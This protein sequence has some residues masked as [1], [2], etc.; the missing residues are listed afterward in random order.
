MAGLLGGC[1]SAPS[2][3]PG[4]MPAQASDDATVPAMRVVF[5]YLD[6]QA[7]LGL[8]SPAR[9]E[10]FLLASWSDNLGQV[11]VRLQQVSSAIPLVGCE[12]IVHLAGDHVLG[13]DGHYCAH[14][15]LSA[16]PAINA[17]QARDALAKALTSRQATVEI[18]RLVYFGADH[19]PQLSYEAVVRSGFLVSNYYV[20]AANGAI[21]GKL[22]RSPAGN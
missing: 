16:S 2:R 7:N 8:R 13:M 10:Y 6:S 19:D 22:D 17:Q 12:A 5:S 11:H 1:V 3:Q 9:E 18:N 15:A 14:G 20:S 21:L 4:D